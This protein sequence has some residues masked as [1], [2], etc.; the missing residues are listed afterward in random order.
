MKTLL[1][2]LLSLYVL[3]VC[4]RLHTLGSEK[5][6]FPVKTSR[7]VYTIGLLVDIILVAWITMLLM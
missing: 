6:V 2:I 1:W 7:S 3:K 5:T 4:S